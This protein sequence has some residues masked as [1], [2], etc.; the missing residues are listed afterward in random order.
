MA[1]YN[2]VKHERGDVKCDL[3]TNIS[4]GGIEKVLSDGFVPVDPVS[5]AAVDY[6]P[7]H[8]LK[9]EHLHEAFENG[10]IDLI[11]EV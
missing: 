6:G 7:G 9:I 3:I 8:D 10:D 1:I 2:Y 11:R 5:W 4:L